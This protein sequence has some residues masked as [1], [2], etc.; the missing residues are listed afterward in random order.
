[1]FGT[2]PIWKPT[3]SGSRW[4]F[5]M[6][7][8]CS[9]LCLFFLPSLCAQSLNS[10]QPIA[11]YLQR[12]WQ[13][14]DGLPEANVQ[15]LAQT[16]DGYLWVGTTGGL[17]RFDGEKFTLFNHQTTPAFT[18]DGI[19]S[20]LVGKNGDLWIGTFG[21]GLV[22]Y[23]NG[24]FRHYPSGHGFTLGFVRSIAESDD[25]TLFVGTYGGLFRM[26]AEGLVRFASD[27]ATL[28]D[29]SLFAMSKD[30]RGSIWV[31]ATTLVRIKDG[32]PSSYPMSGLPAQTLI[33]TIVVDSQD[34][35]WIGTTA[36]LF[37][38]IL[39]NDD[40][41]L[42]FSRVTSIHGG[43]RT[44]FL[45]PD[46]RLWVGTSD[47]GSFLLDGTRAVPLTTPTSFPSNAVFAA[48]R[49]RNGS[50]WIGTQAG[51]IRLVHP[52]TSI[53]FLPKS[54]DSV[55]QTISTDT[56][57]HL[58]IASTRLYE[59]I[60]GHPKEVKIPEL[61]QVH[62]VTVL[63][64]RE[65]VLWLGTFDQGVYQLKNGHVTHLPV[66]EGLRDIRAMLEGHDGTIWVAGGSGIRRFVHGQLE[67]ERSVHGD[68]PRI[69]GVH[70]LFEDQSGALW[71]GADQGLYL[72]RDNKLEANDATRTIQ[73]VPVW[74]LHEESSG[75]LWIGTNGRG[76]YRWKNGNVNSIN[77][78]T[79]P[80]PN[81]IYAILQTQDG[82]IWISGSN[83]I[84]A[85][86][87]Q[88]LNAF[89]DDS[90][91]KPSARLY[92][93]L[94]GVYTT[95]M[96][97]GLQPAGAIAA[98]GSLWFPS[99]YGPVRITPKQQDT[100]R[101]LP[102][103]VIR[104]V[105]VNGR[106]VPTDTLN[107]LDAASTR[108]D[109]QYG[110]ID[111]LP[112]ADLRFR[113]KLDGF[114]EQWNDAG[115]FR[116]VTYTNLPPGH[117]TF[118][119]LVYNIEDPN[120]H[121]ET[122]LPLYRR[123]P[124]YRTWWFYMGCG[125][126]T[127]C[128]IALVHFVRTQQL[129]ARFRAVIEERNRVAREMHDTLLSGCTG[130]SSLLEA[131]AMTSQV[132]GEPGRSLLE[133]ARTQISLTIEEARQ[134]IWGL[135]L[136]HSLSEQVS[137]NDLLSETLQQLRL[138]FGTTI[139]FNTE[140]RGFTLG[141]NIAH[142][143]LMATREA[144]LNALRHSNPTEVRLTV[145]YSRQHIGIRVTDN[146][147]GFDTEGGSF[148]GKR[149]HYGLA[150]MRERV[151]SLGGSLAIKSSLDNGTELTILLDLTNSPNTKVRDIQH[152]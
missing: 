107:N 12:V 86:S 136:D 127:L 44:L 118:R 45:F 137:L 95:Q 51:L 73:D 130:V 8:S 141:K 145:Q 131:M 114:D 149:E 38:S 120:E 25:G 103:V 72:W 55:S 146:G 65:G 117:Y 21:G 97:G 81:K 3:K 70:V 20:L 6:I 28:R 56:K 43:V 111:L 142:Q 140:G 152:G 116:T 148:D 62:V 109:I 133:S 98:D 46:G 125:L 7:G 27:V 32:T 88:R 41:P 151:E 16:P 124:Y 143:L 115:T 23:R 29:S 85:V 87:S 10:D 123:P 1:M 4:L 106:E 105:L 129:T 61:R 108:L 138:Q 42:H 53:L 74:S 99:L 96:F 126:A 48:L 91:L 94:S 100:T 60:D 37:K 39:S 110:A 93:A 76:L 82:E 24:V 102:P 15:A 128:G 101:Q 75:T 80:L 19:A 150:V 112:Q 121:S 135:K 77:P 26:T 84:Y 104:S 83:G 134:A 68:S 92:S 47:Q 30:R 79:T 33:R 49:D 147:R 18:V 57:G 132:P 122:S 2:H 22:R 34:T 11:T 64:D 63:Q 89:V 35:L 59:V 5:S 14:Q 90:R 78:S 50:Y 31:G 9:V 69:S 144:L 139:V 66:Q 58:W 52:A 40:A 13:S 36:G 54:S 17:A 113:Y 67:P 71:I 119:V